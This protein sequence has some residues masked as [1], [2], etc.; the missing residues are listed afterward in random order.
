MR[1]MK[2]SCEFKIEDD[3]LKKLIENSIDS[4][5][6]FIQNWFEFLKKPE[7]L[8]GFSESAKCLILLRF[9]V[10]GLLESGFNK[11][12]ALEI[13]KNLFKID[14]EQLSPGNDEAH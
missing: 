12:E 5:E 2:F 3:E 13:L 14:K 10:M 1:T 7:G 4:K 9:T 11:D 6:E 8:Q